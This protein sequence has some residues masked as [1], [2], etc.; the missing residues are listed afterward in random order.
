MRICPACLRSDFAERTLTSHIV[1]NECSA[2][3]LFLST[4]TR[5][6]VVEAEFARVNAEAYRASVGVVRQRQ[7]RQV[8]NLVGECGGDGGTW[9]DIGCGFGYF[10]DEARRAGFEV[11]GVEPDAT[12]F[13]HAAL[14]LGADRVR[15]GLM[16]DATIAD[17]SA[18][19]VST[20]DVLEH[21][22]VDELDGFARLVRRKLK[23]GGLWAIKLPS[24]EGLYFKTAH[25]LLPIAPPLVTS[26]IKRLWQ[27]EYEF[28]HTV[29]FNR[30]ALDLFLRKHGFEVVD[31]RYIEDVPDDTV[32]D[33]LL[34]DDTIP[35][36][37]AY[38][39]APIL[40]SINAIERRRGVTDALLML[41]R[42]V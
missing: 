13:T 35:K 28:P 23:D 11:L 15:H 6:G 12:A 32:I 36:W 26:A 3:G 40:Y 9:L 34:M 22:P 1:I 4:I 42:R 19:V 30:R 18:A 25:R 8:L 10:L 33:R 16:N 24:S 14:L 39:S 7:A 37:Q 41:A 5:V 27:S 17:A 31:A 21:I 2:C 29:Y 20:L 38:L